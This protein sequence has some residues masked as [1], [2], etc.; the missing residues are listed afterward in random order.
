MV[1]PII[2]NI[3][4][5]IYNVVTA[6]PECLKMD[7][8]HHNEQINAEGAHCGTTHCRAGWVVAKAGKLGRELELQTSTLFAAMQIY[9]K[10]SPDIEVN[11]PRY[12]EDN[13]TALADMK[14]CSELELAKG[15]SK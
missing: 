6:K 4:T 2:P 1:I 14:R 12:F 15:L 5:E 3:H 9:H 13:S 7:S 8:W 10:S 11:I